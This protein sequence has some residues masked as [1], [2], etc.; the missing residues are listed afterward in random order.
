[1]KNSLE[2]FITAKIV[3]HQNNRVR[4]SED[5]ILTIKKYLEFFIVSSVLVKF[6]TQQTSFF[7]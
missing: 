1:M 7:Q 6:L 2:H 5:D 4:P 3:R